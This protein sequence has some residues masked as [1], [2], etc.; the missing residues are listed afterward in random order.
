MPFREEM[1]HQEI[2]ELVTEYIEGA[3]T[4]WDRVRFERHIATCADC[5]GSLRQMRLTIRLVGMLTPEAI[6]ADGLR[7]LTDAFRDWKRGGAR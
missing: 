2:V 4:P 7:R 3:L 6:P 1:T 5:D